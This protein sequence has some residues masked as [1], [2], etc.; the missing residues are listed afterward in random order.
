MESLLW[1]LKSIAVVRTFISLFLAPSG[2]NA[3]PPGA[4][5]TKS[6]YVVYSLPSGLETVHTWTEINLEGHLEQP[7]EF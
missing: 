7:E 2:D 3:R 5:K 1:R 4:T 6:K